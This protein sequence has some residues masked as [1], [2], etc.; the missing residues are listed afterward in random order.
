MDDQFAWN[1]NKYY[2]NRYSY[3]TFRSYAQ[4]ESKWSDDYRVGFINFV[5]D[6]TNVLKILQF[7]IKL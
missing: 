6:K 3:L 1:T 2:V 7:K 4:E 5:I